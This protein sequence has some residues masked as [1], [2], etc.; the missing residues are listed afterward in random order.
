MV[1]LLIIGGRTTMHEIQVFEKIYQEYMSAVSR[2][3]LGRV[4]DRLGLKLDKGE[5]VIPFYGIPYRVSGQGIADSQGR[6]PNHAVSVILCKYLLL[7][8]EGEP[9]ESEWVTYKDFKDAAPFVGGFSNNAEKPIIRMF[10]GRLS[11]LRQACL[12][13]TGRPVDAGID[14]DLVMRLDALPKV[15]V[16]LLFNDRDDDFPAQCS[17]L[18]ERRA[19]KY[20]DM[21]CLAM[22]GWAL[23]E[24][25]KRPAI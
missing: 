5:A 22:T 19:E 21:E 9:V 4:K 3:D 8:P 7:C 24:W 14:A 1:E 16:L 12:G 10:S 15:P 2:V 23:S 25:L 6:R 17:L 11:E 13:L 18:F 20:L